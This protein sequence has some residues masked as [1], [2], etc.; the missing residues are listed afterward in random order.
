M[1]KSDM[2]KGGVVRNSAAGD[3]LSV[4]ELFLRLGSTPASR[5]AKAESLFRRLRAQDPGDGGVDALRGAL[6]AAASM[7]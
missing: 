7:E 1:E 3:G 4:Q 2:V 5:S 6:R